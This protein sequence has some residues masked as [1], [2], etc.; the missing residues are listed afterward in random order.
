MKPTLI[1]TILAQNTEDAFRDIRALGRAASWIHFDVLDHTLVPFESWFDP[2]SLHLWNVHAN[3][4]LHLMVNDPVSF[5]NRCAH[6]SHLKRILWH[7]EA[8]IDHAALL[9]RCH[10]RN[11]EAGLALSPDTV[12]SRLIP[13][14]ENID[15]VLVM[16]VIPGKSGQTLL[17]HTLKTLQ[18]LS[19]LV[20]RLKLGFDGGV[21]RSNLRSVVR[22]GATRVYGHSIVFNTKQPDQT[23]GSLNTFLKTLPI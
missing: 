5:F 11:I 19:C 15:E 4:E 14:L 3:I 6:L 9:K 8:P 10:R 23:L 18:T 7:I 13:F 21:T 22:H 16:G 2:R 20:P 12:L 1:P 17:P